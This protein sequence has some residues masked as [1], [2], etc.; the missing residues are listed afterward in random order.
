[1]SMAMLW[2]LPPLSFPFRPS[3]CYVHFHFTITFRPLSRT[4]LCAAPLLACL[5]TFGTYPNG[6]QGNKRGED[7]VLE[8]LSQNGF[9]VLGNRICFVTLV[10]YFV[11]NS[12][13]KFGG[14]SRSAL[15][16]GSLTAMSHAGHHLQ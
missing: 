9:C 7:R 8:L 14:G 2:P 12:D 3:E 4:L 5:L 13:D 1:M 10:S 6:W 15:K 11:Y 16:I